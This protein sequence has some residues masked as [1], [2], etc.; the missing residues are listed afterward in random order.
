[1]RRILENLASN[2]VKYGSPTDPITVT[3][4][5]TSREVQI[6]V[7]NH[8]YAIPPEE[9]EHVFDSFSRAAR[10]ER[11]ATKGWGL[12]LAV[13]K[14]LTEAHGGTV[15]VDSVDGAGTTFKVDLPLHPPA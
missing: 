8:G 10:P 13:V 4:M 1:M 15:R 9:R 7:H 3:L 6:S 2:A 11:G 5:K 14:G 12:G